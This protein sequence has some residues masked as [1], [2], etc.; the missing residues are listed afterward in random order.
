MTTPDAAKLPV[1]KRHKGDRQ[2]TAFAPSHSRQRQFVDQFDW[3]LRPLF[4]SST[5]NSRPRAET[6]WPTPAISD[7][8]F[9]ERRYGAFERSFRPPDE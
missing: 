6:F 2:D 3:R 1:G 5:F 4:L 9:L 7:Q 8:Q